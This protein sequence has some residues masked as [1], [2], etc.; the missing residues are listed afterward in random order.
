MAEYQNPFTIGRIKENVKGNAA[1]PV[2]TDNR[3]VVLFVPTT[4]E[5]E[6]VKS[7]TSI[8]K[9]YPKAKELYRGW[10]RSQRDFKPGGFQVNQVLS[11]TEI[12][13]CI[14]CIEVDGETGFEEEALR[15]SLD[16]LGRHASLN[17]TNVHINKCGSPEEWDVIKKLIEEL[18]ARRGVN[19]FLY[20]EEN[21]G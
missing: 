9:V 8:E 19:V 15:S 7:N 12:A 13:H 10:W 11:D 3:T 1:R 17:R 4:G 2:A 20:D 16:K 21:S 6:H 18:V 14:A 5:F